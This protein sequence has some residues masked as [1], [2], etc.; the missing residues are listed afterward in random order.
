MHPLSKTSLLHYLK[1]PFVFL[2]CIS[3]PPSTL[4]NTASKF[5][6]NCPTLFHSGSL[7]LQSTRCIRKSP[8]QNSS[9]DSGVVHPCFTTRANQIKQLL[10]N[11]MKKKK[12]NSNTELAAETHTAHVCGAELCRSTWSADLHR[13]GCLWSTNPLKRHSW[14][15]QSS[16][17]RPD[18][19]GAASPL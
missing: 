7:M 11:N 2:A 6:F 17:E 8:S 10:Y 14:T 15:L 3:T 4:V 9:T 16:L 12:K 1:F 18:R 13:K 19:T 5:Y